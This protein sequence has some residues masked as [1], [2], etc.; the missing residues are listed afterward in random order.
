MIAQ[1]QIHDYVGKVLTSSRLAVLATTS[2]SQPHAS[3]IAITAM[4][5]L[6]HLH[7]ATYRNTRKYANLIQ[8]ENVSILFEHR[9][10]TNTC[11][12]INVL[13]AFGKAKEVEVANYETILNSHLLLHPDL[14]SFLLS[15]D[16]AL[17]QVKVEFYQIVLG[18]DEVFWWE[19]VS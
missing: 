13:T 6:L 15:S 17:F 18:I 2:K 16:C 10:D 1:T 8:N 4:D 11:S 19:N 14:E 9:N 5:D 12:D 7:F 3:I